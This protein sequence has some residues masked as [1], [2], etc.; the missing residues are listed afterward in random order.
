MSTPALGLALAS[1]VLIVAP[2]GCEHERF[3]TEPPSAGT[4]PPLA[5]AR[6]ALDRIDERTPLPLLPMMALHQ[7]QN[8]REHLQAVQG[9][10]AALAIGDFVAV[11]TYKQQVIDEA[12]WAALP[13]TARSGVER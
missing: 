9:I 2:W 5:S 8:M 10:T 1:A 12:T 11:S 4:T 7:K 13:A 3:T 6:Q